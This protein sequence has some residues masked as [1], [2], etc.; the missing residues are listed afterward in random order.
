MSGNNDNTGNTGDTRSINT[1]IAGGDN[2]VP[3]F[4]LVDPGQLF[5]LKRIGKNR[6]ADLKTV[7]LASMLAMLTAPLADYAESGAELSQGVGLVVPQIMAPRCTHN[8]SDRGLAASATAGS[9][10]RF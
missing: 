6:R 2:T 10:D 8:R 7:L 9:W 4:L 3:R 5:H 1:F